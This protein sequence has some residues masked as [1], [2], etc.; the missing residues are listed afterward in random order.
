MSLLRHY[1]HG[2]SHQHRH[3][4]PIHATMPDSQ[5]RWQ[6]HWLHH[7]Q[8]LRQQRSLAGRW[9]PRIAAVVQLA[10]I[11][12]PIAILILILEVL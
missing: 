3:H 10:V 8:Q 11:A 5:L 7:Q 6:L 1:G 12:I 2:S 9:K 4:S